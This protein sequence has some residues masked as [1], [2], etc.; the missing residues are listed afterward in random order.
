VYSWF[1]AAAIE[2]A[3]SSIRFPVFSVNWV[4]ISATALIIEARLLAVRQ[5]KVIWLAIQMI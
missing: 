1:D 3:G 5:A 4:P 2:L